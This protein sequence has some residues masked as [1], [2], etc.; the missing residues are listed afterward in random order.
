[1]SAKTWQPPAGWGLQRGRPKNIQGGQ[2]YR[3]IEGGQKYRNK[4]RLNIY[5]YTGR[6]KIKEHM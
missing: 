5:E 4:I 6:P 3:N 1:M 2:K